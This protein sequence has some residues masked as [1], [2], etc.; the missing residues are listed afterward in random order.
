MGNYPEEYGKINA[1]NLLNR[2][3]AIYGDQLFAEKAASIAAGPGFVERMDEFYEW[4]Y[5]N[6][7]L[8]L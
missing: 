5:Q 2:V 6:D 4:C 3:K 8:P 7:I 1:V